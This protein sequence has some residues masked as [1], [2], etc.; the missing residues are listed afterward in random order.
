MPSLP[1]I[2]G[3][4]K[5]QLQAKKIYLAAF[6]RVYIPGILLVW[7]E[8]NAFTEANPSLTARWFK[9]DPRRL[10]KLV[11][12]HLFR[13]GMRLLSVQTAAQILRR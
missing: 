1:K 4:I 13:T 7:L 10:K 6:R 5:V 2:D 3:L 11:E 8:R 12:I 9:S